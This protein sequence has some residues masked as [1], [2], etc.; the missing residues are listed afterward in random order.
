M[1]FSSMGQSFR[2]VCKNALEINLSVLDDKYEADY[3]FDSDSSV[4]PRAYSDE[5]IKYKIALPIPIIAGVDASD[6]VEISDILGVT[7]TD[8]L[9]ILSYKRGALVEGNDIKCVDLSTFVDIKNKGAD[10]AYIG[11]LAIER[12][13]VARGYADKID[14]L[15]I[16]EIPVV[17]E[18]IEA[19]SAPSPFRSELVFLYYRID[20]L[21]MRHWRYCV[22][23]SPLL[24]HINEH[25]MLRERVDALLS[26]FSKYNIFFE[27]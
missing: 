12:M 19:L 2:N 22:P 21:R 23:S 5:N 25:R 7:P 1:L 18:V 14:V 27:E 6:L 9:N 26:A 8:V 15:F 17:P 24:V 11:A 16:T 20:K 13:L 3:E 10:N 4:E